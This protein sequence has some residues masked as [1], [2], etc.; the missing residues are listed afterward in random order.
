[1][2]NNLLSK[3]DSIFKK[4]FFDKSKTIF[5]HIHFIVFNVARSNT[6]FFSSYVQNMLYWSFRDFNISYYSKHSRIKDYW[7]K[8]FTKELSYQNILNKIKVMKEKNVNDNRR[9]L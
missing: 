6:K 4:L 8:K 2:N 3:F 1:M 7:L 9:F 5:K